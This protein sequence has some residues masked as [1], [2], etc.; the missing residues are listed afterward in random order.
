MRWKIA[1]EIPATSNGIALGL[2]GAVSGI[3]NNLL[4]VAGGNNF[5]GALPWLGG[6]KKYYDAVHV[7]S[8]QN[9]TLVLL[10]AGSW[11]LPS[12]I[13]YAAVA[14][15]A[16]GIIYAGGEHEE[17]ISKKTFLLHWDT[18]SAS[19]Q[20]Q[21]LPDLPVAL[22]NAAAAVYHQRLYVTG[23]ESVH[24]VSDHVYMLDLE[25]TTPGF[26]Q[27]PSVPVGLSHA[28]A[29]IQSDGQHD[30]LF[31]LGGRKKNGNGVS[32]LYATVFAFD[33]VT[34]QWSQKKSLPYALSA[35]AGV[36]TGRHKLLLLGGDKGQRFHETELVLAGIGAATDSSKKKQLN[37][38]RI[39]LQST[40][41]GF[42]NQVL[43]YNTVTQSTRINGTIPYQTPVTTRAFFWQNEI[44]IPGGE[45]KAGVRSSHILTASYN[46][47]P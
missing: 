4:L 20:V 28:L 25:N 7:F 17:G 6:K 44:I 5:P 43:E 29:L 27:L 12:P 18:A 9:D 45:I 30:C 42:S 14:E 33:L 21:S 31:L 11:K 32:D 26:K 15:S 37:E 13:A 34:H 23:G 22:S 10:R 38:E 36:A 35:G 3:S 39:S 47:H 46:Q 41:P 1:G 40:H 16:N 8:K 24:G 2:A 19:V